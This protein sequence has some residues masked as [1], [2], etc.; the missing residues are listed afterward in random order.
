MKWHIV[1]SL[2]LILVVTSRAA[3]A[4]GQAPSSEEQAMHD[5]AESELRFPTLK[6]EN[7]LGRE[8]MLPRDF[9]GE[10]NLVFVAFQREQQPDVD[11]WLPLARRLTSQF[12]KLRYY[13]TPVIGRFYKVMKPV[14]DGGMRSGIPDRASREATVTI[15]TNKEPF[16]KALGIGTEETIYAFL[17]DREGIVRWRAQGRFTDESGRSLEE[18][19]HS[20]SLIQSAG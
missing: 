1:M 4:Q 18:R 16:R 13:E 17:L 11:T 14:I 10:W 3:L 20:T 19:L 15:Y 7:L 12:P 8:L 5:T 6:A 9:A 2:M